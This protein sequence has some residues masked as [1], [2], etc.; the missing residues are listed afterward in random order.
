MSV[1]AVLAEPGEGACPV[2]T[3]LTV[4]SSYVDKTPKTPL[5]HFTVRY[6]LL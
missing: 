5:R 6:L 3:K 2:D 4:P 1:V